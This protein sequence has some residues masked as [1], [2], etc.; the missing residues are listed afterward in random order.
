MYT[1]SL[2][3]GRWP[4]RGWLPCAAAVL[5]RLTPT[6]TRRG[7]AVT[8]RSTS[9]FWA[10]WRILM[11]EPLGMYTISL[12]PGRWPQRGW[13]PCAAAVLERLTPT[14]TRRGLALTVRSTSVFWVRPTYR[15][16]DVAGG[17]VCCWTLQPN[18]LE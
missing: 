16:T 3:P 17:P 15:S 18:H 13:L 14:R 7:L 5:E 9:V 4:Q 11:P 1:I 12:S 10:R 2:S 8:V 6:R